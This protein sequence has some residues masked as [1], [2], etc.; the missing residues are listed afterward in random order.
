MIRNG[1][2]GSDDDAIA[3]WPVLIPNAMMII[4]QSDSFGHCVSSFV[5]KP[6]RC[7]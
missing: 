1:V 7:K 4:V 6:C 3:G 2:G 5:Q